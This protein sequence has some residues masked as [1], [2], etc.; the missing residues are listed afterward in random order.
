[1]HPLSLTLSHSLYQMSVVLKSSTIMIRLRLGTMPLFIRAL[2]SALNFL[3]PSFQLSILIT[4]FFFCPI[5]SHIIT[6]ISLNSLY[7]FKANFDEDLLLTTTSNFFFF[8]NIYLLLH[9]LL[10][11][12]HHNMTI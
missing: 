1:M 12:T 11:Q 9:L 8:Q 7:I 3:I 6:F 5:S 4:I 2:H 10:Y